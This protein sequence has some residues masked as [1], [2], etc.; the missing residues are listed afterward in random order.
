[1]ELTKCIGCNN[2][3]EIEIDDT[4]AF[5]VPDKRLLRTKLVD[6]CEELLDVCDPE[7]CDTAQES[8]P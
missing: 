4:E 1:M 2:H 6:Y 7:I 8:R 3:R 5:D